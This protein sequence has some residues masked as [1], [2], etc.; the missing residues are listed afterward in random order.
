M[1]WFVF[2]TAE[3]FLVIAPCDPPPLQPYP[4]VFKVKIGLPSIHDIIHFYA[5]TLKMNY[6]KIKQ[7]LL[8]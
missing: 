7:K 3:V 8:S 6:F 4:S 2:L 5:K 1:S